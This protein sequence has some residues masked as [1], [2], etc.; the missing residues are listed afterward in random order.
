MHS[1]NSEEVER[2]LSRAQLKKL[3]ALAQRTIWKKL[4]GEPIPSVSEIK[5]QVGTSDFIR[6]CVPQGAFVTLTIGR[7]LR[8]CI[9]S[10]M[11]E[12]P[13]W[14]S[15]RAN[16]LNAAFHDPRFEPLSKEEF[17]KTEIEVS[18]LSP[19]YELKYSG[20]DDLI[21]KLEPRVHGVLLRFKDGSGATFLPQ[22]WDDLPTADE[23]L[24]HL[25]MK[26]GKPAGAW[27]NE[28]PAVFTYTVQHI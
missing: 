20:A 21:S 16:A 3:V 19:L 26:A 14:E 9:G 2:E 4:S 24:S 18:A 25:C 5:A 8:G 28:K 23:F 22:V 15:V 1:K 13:L 10:I 12:G 7:E 27:K 6:L 17:A 11:P